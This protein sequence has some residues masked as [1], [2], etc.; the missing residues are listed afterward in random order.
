MNK[1]SSM[2]EFSI[3][4]FAITADLVYKMS[5]SLKDLST[6]RHTI[7]RE[8]RQ[9]YLLP[10]YFYVAQFTHP[11]ISPTVLYTVQMF[12]RMDKHYSEYECM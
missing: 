12:H 11:S 10:V 2:V 8:L 9:Q 5:V 1:A 6:L 4:Y 7:G 3:V